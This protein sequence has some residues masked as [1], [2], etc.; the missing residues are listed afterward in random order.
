[1][2]EFW[3][4]SEAESCFLSLSLTGFL[5]KVYGIL[6]AQLSLTILVAAIFMYT[7]GIKGFVQSRW[8]NHPPHGSLFDLNPS[9]LYFPLES[10]A[11]E[12]PLPF[13]ISKDLPRWEY[14]WILS[15]SVMTWLSGQP[16]TLVCTASQIPLLFVKGILCNYIV[17]DLL[18]YIRTCC[19]ST[20]A[21]A[22]SQNGAEF[23]RQVSKILLLI[24]APKYK[25]LSTW[26]GHCT[27]IL[28]WV[29]EKTGVFTLGA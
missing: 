29:L 26:A 2:L 16:L 15:L 11:L 19:P 3:I 8:S 24:L 7:E 13:R 14:A 18:G 1:M 20:S 10:V 21:W 5:R 27:Q 4:S 17:N 9:L 23:R 25:E 6:T 28:A 22:L 12:T